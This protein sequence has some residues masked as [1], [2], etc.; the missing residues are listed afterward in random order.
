MSRKTNEDD[1]EDDDGPYCASR[2][3]AGALSFKSAMSCDGKQCCNSSSSD[4]LSV[5]LVCLWLLVK[6]EPCVPVA[7][8]ALQI[9]F[10]VWGD[11]GVC[12]KFIVW[13]DGGVYDGAPQ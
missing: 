7:G 6:D 4:K 9:A 13:G 2:D 11:D 10:V 8:G 12:D 1:D 5:G 3:V